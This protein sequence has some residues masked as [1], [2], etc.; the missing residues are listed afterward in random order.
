MLIL[1]L[2]AAIIVGWKDKDYPWRVVLEDR[3]VQV[4]LLT[5]LF[6]WTAIIYCSAVIGYLIVT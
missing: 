4:R 1:F 5:V 6:T 3:D 2:Q